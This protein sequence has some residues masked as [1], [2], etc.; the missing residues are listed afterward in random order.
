LLDFFGR[1]ETEHGEVADVELNDLLPFLFH[2]PRSV[3]DGTSNVVTDIGQLGGF[4]NGFQSVS[5]SVLGGETYN[6]TTLTHPLWRHQRA[7]K[8]TPP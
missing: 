6:L 1:I 5:S 3:H 4:L 2:L 8:T 7:A